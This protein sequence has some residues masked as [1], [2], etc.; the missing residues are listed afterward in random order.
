[1]ARFNLLSMLQVIFFV[2]NNLSNLSNLS[3]TRSI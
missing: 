3:A 2:Q 1:M